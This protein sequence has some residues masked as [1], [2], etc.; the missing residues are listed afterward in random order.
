MWVVND[1][2]CRG[3]F[4]R[5]AT[6]KLS[7]LVKFINEYKIKISAHKMNTVRQIYD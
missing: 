3:L 5:A 2:L 4:L 7:L 1:T 6:P